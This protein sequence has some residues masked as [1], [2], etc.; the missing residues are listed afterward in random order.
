MRLLK[1][2]A[3]SVAALAFLV[4]LLDWF[5]GCGE[6]FIT[7]YG[8]VQGECTGRLILKDLGEML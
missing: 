3:L 1:L 6:V 7:K 5:G 2:I 8:K 4:L